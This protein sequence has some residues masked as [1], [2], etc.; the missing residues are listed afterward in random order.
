MRKSA[1][2]AQ[3]KVVKFNHRQTKYFA[4]INFLSTLVFVCSYFGTPKDFNEVHSNRRLEE[5]RSYLKAHVKD[6]EE[7]R[8]VKEAIVGDL[9]D[10]GMNIDWEE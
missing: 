6:A 7:H 9:R 8:A 3:R 2:C 1:R 4:V 5:V 10:L